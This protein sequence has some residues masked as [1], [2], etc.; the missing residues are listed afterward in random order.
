MVPD[1]AFRFRGFFGEL[2]VA[3]SSTNRTSRRRVEGLRPPKARSWR[4]YAIARVR[5]DR[6]IW[7]DGSLPYKVF[8]R[9]RRSSMPS[10][11]R[12]A[13]SPA[14]APRSIAGPR[15][16]MIAP[17][18][19]SRRSNRAQSPCV[20]LLWGGDPDRS[21]DTHIARFAARSQSRRSS[22]LLG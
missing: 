19:D 17:R 12:L 21:N 9:S 3:V 7:P 10:F 15:R 6:P 18:R 2:P 20:V 16:F 22:T 14:S 4:R 13:I 1:W 8:Q 5:N 11:D